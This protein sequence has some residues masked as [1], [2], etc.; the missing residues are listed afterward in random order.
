MT[1]RSYLIHA[2]A[3]LV[4]SAAG[5]FGF[6]TDIE[7]LFSAAALA[8]LV[9]T[10]VQLIAL[11]GFAGSDRTRLFASKATFALWCGL[12]FPSAIVT[13][14]NWNPLFAAVAVPIGFLMAYLLISILKLLW[15]AVQRL[16]AR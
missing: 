1:K 5:V 15:S 3:L 6:A 2:I 4:I 9:G 13:L 12:M 14:P 8:L 16:T 10:T 7:P 11:V